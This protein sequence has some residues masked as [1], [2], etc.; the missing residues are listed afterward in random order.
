MTCTWEH[1]DDSLCGA[2][3]THYRVSWDIG[4]TTD[5]KHRR[6]YYCPVHLYRVRRMTSDDEARTRWATATYAVVAA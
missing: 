6:F 1:E 4:P 3:A 2:P 5:P